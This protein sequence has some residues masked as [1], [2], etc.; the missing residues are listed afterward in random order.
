MRLP[1]IG[2]LKRAGFMLKPV[3]GPRDL[4]LGPQRNGDG[5]DE[6]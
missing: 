2:E 3:A 1:A 5:D 4:V 6:T